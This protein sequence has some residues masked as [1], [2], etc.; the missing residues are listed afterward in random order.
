[1]ML[2]FISAK[3]YVPRLRLFS[4]KTL[5][6][7]LALGRDAEIVEWYS[8]SPDPSNGIYSMTFQCDLDFFLYIACKWLGRKFLRIPEPE[9]DLHVLQI[10]MDSPYGGYIP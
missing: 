2:F 5:L 8:H 7:L 3:I 10:L 9:P 1:M 6:I 4:V